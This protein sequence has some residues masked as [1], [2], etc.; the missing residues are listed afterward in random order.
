MSKKTYTLELTAEELLEEGKPWGAHALQKLVVLANQ[1]KADREADELRL[2]WHTEW[3][4]RH[5]GT[6]AVYAP[7]NGGI[8]PLSMTLP[9]RA[10]KLMSAAPE[11]LE[12]VKAANGHMTGP[13]GRGCVCRCPVTDGHADG[14]PIAR[15]L[16]KVETGIPEDK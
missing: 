11:L 4:N 5:S 2:P 10:A 6:M 16:R 1:A 12:A 7:S 14:C 13:R 9:E 3:V 8:T 15:A